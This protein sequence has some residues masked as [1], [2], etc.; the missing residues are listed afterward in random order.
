LKKKHGRKYYQKCST[1]YPNTHCDR[2]LKIIFK[3]KAK[4]IKIYSI[5]VVGKLDKIVPLERPNIGDL[6]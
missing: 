2:L 4:I 3:I 5:L 1:H 6:K